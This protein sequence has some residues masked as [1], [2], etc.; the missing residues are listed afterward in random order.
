MFVIPK[1]FRNRLRARSGLLRRAHGNDTE[2][3]AGAPSGLYLARHTVVDQAD[4]LRGTILIFINDAMFSLLWNF[5][6]YHFRYSTSI[7]LSKNGKL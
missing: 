3:P 1:S 7:D 5:S 2:Q 6:F 4:H